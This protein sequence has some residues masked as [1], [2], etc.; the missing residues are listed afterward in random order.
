MQRL[1]CWQWLL[2]V[3]LWLYKKL[4]KL[5]PSVF[6]YIGSSIDFDRGASAA[7]VSLSS[8]LY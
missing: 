8:S 2:C 7:V 5:N 6:C 1:S 3:A 4:R